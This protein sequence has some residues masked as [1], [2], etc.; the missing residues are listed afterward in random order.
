MNKFL[1][2]LILSF[3]IFKITRAQP[4]SPSRT[5]Q[6]ILLLQQPDSNKIKLLVDSGYKYAL[7]GDS[8]AL[9]FTQPAYNLLERDKTYFG[10]LKTSQVNNTKGIYFMF[11]GKYDS[12]TYY[13]NKSLELGKKY[14]EDLLIAKAYNNLGTIG[15]YT[16]DYKLAVEYNLKALELF[17]KLGDSA[18]IAGAFGNLANNYIRLHQIDKAIKYTRLAIPIAEKRTDKR[19]L[20]NLYNTLATCY[21]EVSNDSFLIYQIK[22][23]Q[24]YKELNNLKGLTTAA[25]NLGEIYRDKKNTDSALHYFKEGIVYARGLDDLQSLGTLYYSK[26]IVLNDLKQFDAAIIAIDSAISFSLISGDKLILSRAYKE[27][28]ELLYKKSNYK[29]GYNYFKKYSELNDSIFNKNMQSSVAEM[30]TKYE[31]EKKERKIEEQKFELLK[32]TYW[33][34]AIVGLVTVIILLSISMYKRTRLKQEKRLQAEIIKQQDMATKLVIEAEEKERRRIAGDL[35]DGVGQMMSAAKMNLSS[36]ES[37]THFKTEEDR[38][39]FEKI[40]SLVDES[41]KEV[42]MVSHNMMPNAL[43]KFGL[44]S[45]VKEFI[46]KIDHHMLKVNLHSEGLNDRLDTNVETV[47]YRV[48]QECVNNVIKHSNANTLD[49]SLI[50]DVDGIAC[51]IEDNGN[52]FDTTQRLKFEGI[53]LKNISARIEYLKGTVDFDSSPGKGTLVAIHVPLKDELY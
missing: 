28:S 32:K 29:E 23:Y 3:T 20:A 43:L 45:A 13:Y 52:G 7:A 41:C 37:K 6:S 15:T 22:S 34:V 31:T 53:G 21:G 25:I 1:I 30:Q 49:I 51:T 9:L 19:L 40:I 10:I 44:S 36:F 18:G 47:L 17:E 12:A 27:R 8:A 48:I 5:V 11:T 39:S 24:L 50:K 26:G 33:L 42:R 16:T 35:H 38:L 14:K 4:N 46:D 2:V